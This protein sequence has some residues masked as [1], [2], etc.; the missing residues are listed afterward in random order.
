MDDD[1]VNGRIKSR[2]QYITFLRL[3]LPRPTCTA[4]YYCVFMA[5]KCIQYHNE[6]VLGRRENPVE[7][8]TGIGLFNRYIALGY[9]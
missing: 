3:R 6:Y 5:C 2:F 8:I 7:N 9:A 1:D 4:K